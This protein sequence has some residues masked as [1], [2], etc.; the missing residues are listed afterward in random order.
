MIVE[1]ERIKTKKRRKLKVKKKIILG[2]K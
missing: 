1:W 2:I